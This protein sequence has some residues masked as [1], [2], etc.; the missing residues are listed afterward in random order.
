MNNDCIEFRQGLADSSG[1]R[2]DLLCRHIEQCAD[3]AA[4]LDARTTGTP[5]GLE[6]ASWE[7][8][9]A[10][11]G[12]NILSDIRTVPENGLWRM[13]LAGLSGL[14]LAAAVFIFFIR[15]VPIS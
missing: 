5:R 15:A 1:I 11:L 12:D 4:F 7:T 9:P 8:V 3:C 2:D 10:A 13:I 6:Q 14:A